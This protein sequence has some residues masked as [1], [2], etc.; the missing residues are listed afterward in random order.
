[1]VMAAG[2]EPVSYAGSSPASAVVPDSLTVGQ[3]ILNPLV[4]VQIII[5]QFAIVV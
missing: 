2:L 5:R 3:R 1:M 4:Y